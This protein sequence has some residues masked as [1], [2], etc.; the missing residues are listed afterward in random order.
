MFSEKLNGF[1]TCVSPSKVIDF[2]DAFEEG[3]S[4][5]SWEGSAH[6]VTLEMI[7]SSVLRLKRKLF[8]CFKYFDNQF[9]FHFKTD[10]AKSSTYTHFLCLKSCFNQVYFT[11]NAPFDA[12]LTEVMLEAK[13]DEAFGGGI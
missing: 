13:A 12:A 1:S 6:I 3:T 7:V 5:D 8:C 9:T 2:L 11:E 4:R 10:L